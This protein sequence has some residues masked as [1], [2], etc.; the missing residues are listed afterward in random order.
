MPISLSRY[1]NITS[2]VGAGVNV[3]TRNL[4]ALIVS[5]SNL[6]PSGTV[7]V[8]TQASD[9]GDFFGTASGE[10][11]RAQFYFG[12]VSKNITSV[13][14]LSFWFWNNNAATD[15]LI[16][17]KQGVYQLS[18]FTAI[19]T[20]DFTLQMSGVTAH[21]TGVTLASAGSL[22]AVA[23]AVQVA[24]RGTNAAW[25]GATV[26]YNASAPIGAQFNLDSGTTGANVIAVT[27]GTVS[28][29]AAPLGWLT[30]ATFS[31]G[32][33]AQT[34]TQNLNNLLNTTNNFG[35]FC[36]GFTDTQTLQNVLDAATW[37][38]SVTPNIQFMYT[39]QSTSANASTWCA[40]L[41]NINGC[42]VTIASPTTAEYPEMCP[43]M[44][45][46]ATDYSATNAVSNFMF[47]QFALTP[48][49]TNNADADTFDALL[50][51]YYG[52]TQT[53]GQTLAFYQRGVMMGLAVSPSDQNVYANEIWF[54]DA[55]AASL[56]SLL[57]SVS[58]VP[59]NIAGQGMARTVMQPV[60]QQALSNG[61]IEPGKALTATQ[62]LEITQVT[63]DPKAWQ[64]VQNQGYV[65]SVVIKQ[66][67]LSNGT[68]Q[69]VLTYVLVYSKDDVVR[70]V[71]G[72]DVLI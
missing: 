7:K 3:A 14:Q 56:M 41:R 70:K 57:L 29:L 32:T 2:G 36:L 10:Y 11:R 18:S 37:N 52:V 8:F 13:S 39:V 46:G 50:A 58:Q 28:D 6:L 38:A 69:Y 42:T 35:S 27:V 31:N 9:V 23:A 19:T 59:A 60:I 12:F 44:I 30:G 48:S 24:I 34:L 68:T 61:V 64:T 16:F 1:V 22:A 25:T 40:A 20:G 45:L 53:A 26:T 65:L 17:G 51:N 49:V 47:Y 54:K 21:V 55:L 15:S 5:K 43:M 66:Q 62:Q 63:G 71:I 67:P 72:S 4:N 33:A